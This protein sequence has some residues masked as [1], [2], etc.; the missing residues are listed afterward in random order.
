MPAP[1]SSSLGSS[2]S[3]A[4]TVATAFV[5][6]N[7]LG[8]LIQASTRTYKSTKSSHLRRGST[9]FDSLPPYTDVVIVGAGPTGLTLALSLA[10]QGVSF[11][12][13][14]AAPHPP[15]ESRALTVHARTLEILEDLGVASSFLTLGLR[16]RAIELWVSGRKALSVPLSLMESAAVP[17][18]VPP[19]KAFASLAGARGGAG[20]SSET[21]A[22]CSSGTPF[23][24][25]LILPQATTCQILE[26]RLNQLGHKESPPNLLGF[27]VSVHFGRYNPRGAAAAPGEELP[28]RFG[29][30]CCK[31]VVGCDG[32]RSAVRKAGGISFEGKM[33][34]RSFFVADVQITPTLPSSGSSTVSSSPSP[35]IA[36][37]ASPAMTTSASPSPE[38]NGGISRRLS[39]LHAAAEA[40]L[41]PGEA[42][43]ARLMALGRRSAAGDTAEL[44][45]TP[46]GCLSAVESAKCIGSQSSE[47]ECASPLLCAASDCSL[48]EMLLTCILQLWSA[49]NLGWKL[50]RV[51]RLGAATQLLDSYAEETRHAALPPKLLCSEHTGL[52]CFSLS[53]RVPA[54]QVVCLTDRVFQLVLRPLPAPSSHGCPASAAFA[55]HGEELAT[56]NSDDTHFLP[57]S[58]ARRTPPL[59][60]ASAATVRL[61]A[62]GCADMSFMS[63]L[64][65]GCRIP[66]CLVK[67]ARIPR[68]NAA[69][70][71]DPVA[72]YLFELLGKG[73]HL[74]LLHVMLLPLGARKQNIF[75]CEIA[76]APLVSRYN[77]EAVSTLSRL[78]Q[79]A[80]LASAKS[81]GGHHASFT[82]GTVHRVSPSAPSLFASQSLAAP[83]SAAYFA[84]YPEGAVREGGKM[85][86]KDLRGS[87]F[88][89]P[90]D[91]PSEADQGSDFDDESSFSREGTSRLSSLGGPRIHAAA[92]GE[93]L[94]RRHTAYPRA[95]ALAAATGKQLW[96]S[97]LRVVWCFHGETA[98]LHTTATSTS[99]TSEIIRGN[100]RGSLPAKSHSVLLPHQ[101][102]FQSGPAHAA[103][104]P[105]G[106]V[107][108]ALSKGKAEE[109]HLVQRPLMQL[110]P[111]ALVQ[112]MQQAS[113][114][115]RETSGFVLIDFLGDLQSKFGLCLSDPHASDG[116]EGSCGFSLI[117]PDGYLAHCGK[118]GDTKAA[119]GLLDYLIRF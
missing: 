97:N 11:V 60:A 102:H 43:R 21:A 39:R 48:R 37:A 30:I 76:G 56:D 89:D 72:G 66:D 61:V 93:R 108:H 62:L 58:K 104:A 59:V 84:D 18:R 33:D 14:D 38:P 113:G 109:Y 111:P 1:G 105:C 112:Q 15:S 41:E 32:S 99:I 31:Y 40:A 5:A 29:V 75:G 63:G 13:L 92:A 45:F 51:L 20:D 114:G 74:L 69:D 117:R 23:P 100:S 79:L 47:Q 83:F 28:V 27:P 101:P 87:S 25:V 55:W 42:E 94:L 53:S 71:P 9:A 119:R 46:K 85:G 12:L 57:A 16:C 88:S 49:Y 52:R 8:A 80:V 17:V 24:F 107:S 86:S 95:R 67:V 90:E 77:N 22:A 26:Q 70:L 73:R 78:C 44:H 7:A 6:K 98:A 110:L 50:A 96:A 115:G 68:V 106:V 19:L 2:R 54:E 3:A 91:E 34:P 65:P 64:K 103:S 4:S 35:L 81:A 82:D 118:A 116:A 36:A 10:L